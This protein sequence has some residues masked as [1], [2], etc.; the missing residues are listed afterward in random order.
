MKRVGPSHLE[1]P[2]GGLAATVIQAET[3]VGG[4]NGHNN[5]SW[6]PSRASQMGV[7]WRSFGNSKELN[8]LDMPSV[9]TL[10]EWEQHCIIAV[11][12]SWYNVRAA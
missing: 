7:N 9:Q 5:L 8:L 11:A 2:Q 1:A 4:P 12:G 3:A 10:R 6:R